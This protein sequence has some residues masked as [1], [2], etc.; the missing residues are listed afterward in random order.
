MQKQAQQTNIRE[1]ID[2]DFQTHF[3]LNIVYCRLLPF[4]INAR[5]CYLWIKE[6]INRTNI[7]Q[8][9]GQWVLEISCFRFCYWQKKLPAGNFKKLLQV[10]FA[11][12]IYTRLYYN[13]N[14][15][16]IIITIVKNNNL[17]NI[18]V[19]WNSSCESNRMSNT[20]IVLP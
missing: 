10:S 11:F 17:T 16:N 4:T 18:S 7:A 5:I 6:E 8:W 9:T 3:T 14:N 19:H 20:A 13:N 12:G 15:N 1:N 2:T